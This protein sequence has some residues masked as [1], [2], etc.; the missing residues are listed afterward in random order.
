M[1]TLVL[2]GIMLILLLTQ[3]KI[4]QGQEVVYENG[5]IR[6]N[7]GIL[8]P[9]D[10]PKTV[11]EAVLWFSKSEGSNLVQL[12][13]RVLLAYTIA[14]LYMKNAP[15]MLVKI[16]D[17]TILTGR[18]DRIVDG[19]IKGTP[20]IDVYFNLTE[21]LQTKIA[22]NG[23]EK[24]RFAFIY[25]YLGMNSSQIFDAFTNNCPDKTFTAQKLLKDIREANFQKAKEE[26]KK[27]SLSNGF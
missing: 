1:K 2:N 5:K 3:T 20:C 13:Y 24:V 22:N 9:F 16:G 7:I 25:N 15:E 4:G 26:A 8:F 14:D 23:I 19:I 21:D 27:K 18:T 10:D 12:Q 6:N 11:S 17:G